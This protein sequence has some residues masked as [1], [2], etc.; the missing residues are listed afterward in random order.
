MDNETFEMVLNAVGSIGF[1][2]A[3]AFLLWKYINT[4]MKDLSRALTENTKML[5]RLCDKVDF[6]KGGEHHE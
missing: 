2:I 3:W 1:P 4:V 5:S 6:L